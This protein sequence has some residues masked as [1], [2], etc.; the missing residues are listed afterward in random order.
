MI[1]KLSFDFSTF[2]NGLLMGMA[3]A[4]P[5]VSGGTIAL[6]LGIYNKLIFSLSECLNFFKNRFP[7]ESFA[8]F[9]SS[10]QFLFTL[11]L[12]MLFSYFVVTKVL[13]GS[14]GQEGLL[15]RSSTAPFIFSLFFGLVLS[16]IKEPWQR[17]KSRNFFRYT[18]CFSAFFLV[19]LYTTFSFANEGGNNL[20]IIGGALALTAMLLPGISG[21]LVLLTL[22]QYTV[23]A[24]AIHDSDFT[25]I[26][27]FL[28]GGLLGLVTFV[29]LMNYMLLNYKEDVM[30]VLTGLMLG[31]LATLWPWKES[32]DSKG[33]SPNMGLNQVLEDF[34][35]MHILGT[36][37]S[38]F[39]GLILYLSLKR[40][41]E[42]AK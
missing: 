35:V 8:K 11:G 39:L 2:R 31:S 42:D 32:Y 18:L 4:V 6:I 16:S 13:V 33:V 27:Y 10:F 15:L 1:S 40:L 9:I 7:K 41:E 5:G 12:G 26:F 28:C 23:I 29:P 34:E 37:F 25:V 17:V 19:L 21:A 38:G 20:L 3:D 22:G 36:I 24:N 30:S 14:E